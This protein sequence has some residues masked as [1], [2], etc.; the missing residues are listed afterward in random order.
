MKYVI[1]LIFINIIN[2]GLILVDDKII[3]NLN[4]GKYILVLLVFSII[5][6]NLSFLIA[7]LLKFLLEFLFKSKYNFILIFCI[8]T[9]VINF[10]IEW[11]IKIV[12][13]NLLSILTASVFFRKKIDL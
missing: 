7:F 9:V 4:S 11:N 5:V 3:S 12:G 10:S 1:L 2:I 8:L 6:L 13:Y